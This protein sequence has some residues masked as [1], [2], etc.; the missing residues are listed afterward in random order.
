MLSA[1]VI[2]Q[3]MVT[4]IPSVS[5]SEKQFIWLGKKGE[6]RLE[7][8]AYCA[9]SINSA[10]TRHGPFPNAEKSRGSRRFWSTA[11]TV[12]KIVNKSRKIKRKFPEQ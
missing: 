1:T 8:G 12:E 11:E 7:R 9:I 10:V 4:T 2:P 3:A 5:I 6:K